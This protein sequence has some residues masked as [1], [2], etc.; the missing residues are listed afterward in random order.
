[1]TTPD[2]RADDAE[3]AVVAYEQLRRHALAG[4]PRGGGLGWLWLLREGVATW[5]DRGVAGVAP[6]APSAAGAAVPP[7]S[8]PLRVGVVHVLASIALAHQE[9]RSP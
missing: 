8:Q 4:S 3:A 2:L 7:V 6:A 5:I 9:V 1:V